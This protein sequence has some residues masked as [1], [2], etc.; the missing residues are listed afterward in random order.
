MDLTLN[1]LRSQNMFPCIAI[2]RTKTVKM[3]TVFLTMFKI[4]DCKRHLAVFSYIISNMN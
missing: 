4:E 2:L 1:K 3:S